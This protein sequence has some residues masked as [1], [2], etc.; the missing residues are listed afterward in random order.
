MLNIS[1]FCSVLAE[2]L[3]FSLYVVVNDYTTTKL[4]D[5]YFKQRTFFT[6]NASFI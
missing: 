3:P 1:S 2:L 5:G 4:I 6:L